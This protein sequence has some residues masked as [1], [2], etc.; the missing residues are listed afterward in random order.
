MFN[1]QL[2]LRPST[3][4]CI[5]LMPDTDPFMLARPVTG[6]Q[7][8]FM[9]VKFVQCRIITNQTFFCQI[10]M[11]Q[12]FSPET[13]CTRKKP[14]QLTGERIMRQAACLIR[15]NTPRFRAA[16]DFLRSYQ[17]IYIIIV[18]YFE[19]IHAAILPNFWQLRNSY[20]NLSLFH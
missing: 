3:A 15:L 14:M 8:D 1:L 19:F 10:N 12:N 7:F 5:R 6:H 2:H 17:K 20:M 16:I 4:A 11:I 18:C 9:A 13:G